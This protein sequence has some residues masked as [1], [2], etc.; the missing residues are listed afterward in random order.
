[1]G[2][3]HTF[4]YNPTGFKHLLLQIRCNA[5]A[6]SQHYIFTTVKVPERVRFWHENFTPFLCTPAFITRSAVIG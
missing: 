5:L 4:S 3:I 2:K 1:M 6:V